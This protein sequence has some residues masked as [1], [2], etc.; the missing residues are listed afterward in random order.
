MMP[1][2]MADTA[3]IVM[4]TM[5]TVPMY[6][7]ATQKVG[8]AGMPLKRSSEE[9]YS[10]HVANPAGTAATL[11]SVMDT[12]AKAAQMIDRTIRGLD[13]RMEHLEWAVSKEIASKPT[14]AQ[15][16]YTQ[17]STLANL[18]TGEKLSVSFGKIMKAIADLIS[19]LANKSNPHGVTAA[20]VGAAASSHTH[21]IANVTN[22][23]ATLNAKATTATY[24]ATVTTTWTASG[25]YFYQDI[26]VSGILATDEPTPAINPGSDNA[27][28][29]LYDEAF[30]KV[31]RITTSANSIRVWATE[32]TSTAFPIRLKVVR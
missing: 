20:Q 23:Q 26:A 28:N 30:G 2:R 18:T 3:V 19:H 17:A 32:A 12:Y 10:C 1:V 31:F 27:A 7:P 13:L 22:L 29:L 11:I 14:K 9:M 16:A 4:I 21:T 24:T 25:N 15:G 5:P 8:T 6:Y